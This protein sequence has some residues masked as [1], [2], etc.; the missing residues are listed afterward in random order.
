MYEITW[1]LTNTDGFGEYGSW[2]G[3]VE[4]CGITSVYQ[5][6]RDSGK[7]KAVGQYNKTA[8]EM[9][10]TIVFNTKADWD[11][12]QAELNNLSW[13]NCVCD[14]TNEGEVA[15]VDDHPQAASLTKF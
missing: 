1:H 6:Y 11:T 7:I 2:A 9:D 8:T 4:D 5:D 13:K 12:Y 3:Y 14:V 15:S 10:D